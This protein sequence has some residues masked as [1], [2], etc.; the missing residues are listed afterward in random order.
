[1]SARLTSIEDRGT[2]TLEK[3]VL[4]LN[5]IEPDA[6]IAPRAHLSLAGDRDALTPITGLDKIDRELQQVYAS[7]GHPENWKLL[8]YDVGHR[9]TP[10]MREQIRKW[11]TEKL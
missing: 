6:L 10:E 9:E 2:Y 4:D 11:F 3:L 8:R 1:V 7:A 5:G